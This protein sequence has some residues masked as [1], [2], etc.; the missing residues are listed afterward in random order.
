ML[1]D[2]SGAL[3][4]KS[5][6]HHTYPKALGGHPDQRLADLAAALHTGK[7]GVHSD[8]AAFEG[9]WLRPRKGMTGAQIVEE[10]GADAVENRAA[11]LLLATEVGTSPRDF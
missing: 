5:H 4:F 3:T 2:A 6:G 1:R 8:L 7:G 11:S 9:G 10:F